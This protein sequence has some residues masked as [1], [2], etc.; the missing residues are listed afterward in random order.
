MNFFLD[1]CQARVQITNS[2]D[3]T[4]QYVVDLTIFPFTYYHEFLNLIHSN[5]ILKVRHDVKNPYLRCG[6]TTFNYFIFPCLFCS[7]FFSLF[8]FFIFSFFFPSISLIHQS[9]FL[10]QIYW[11]S[12]ASHNG[13]IMPLTMTPYPCVYVRI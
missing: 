1:P 2:P 6:P 7:I 4:V 11:L 8:F 10:Y 3:F 5:L 9:L 13:P 12:F